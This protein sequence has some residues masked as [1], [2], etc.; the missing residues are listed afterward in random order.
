V[1]R[2]SNANPQT[3]EVAAPQFLRQ[4][5]QAVVSRMPPPLP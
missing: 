1:G 2:A 5:P 4:G 3:D